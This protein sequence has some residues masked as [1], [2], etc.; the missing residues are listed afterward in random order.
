MSKGFYPLE[1]LF[2]VERDVDS[3]LFVSD[4]GDIS[5]KRF[6]ADVAGM[7]RELAG[8]SERC[9]AIY[10]DELYSFAI[11]FFSLL[12]V[13]KTIVLP[14][15]GQSG[16][17]RELA[18]CCDALLSDRTQGTMFEGLN[19]LPVSSGC[20]MVSARPFVISGDAVVKLFTSGSTGEPKMIE[21]KLCHLSREVRVLETTFGE[22]MGASM[23]YATVA[24]HHIYGLLFRLLWPLCAGRVIRTQLYDY[25]ELLLKEITA[26]PAAVLISSPAQLGRMPHIVDIASLGSCL[27]LLFSSGGP[28]GEETAWNWIE[29]LGRAPVEV[30]GSTETGGIAYRKLDEGDVWKAFDGVQISCRP[31]D[32]LLHVSSPYLANENGFTLG[33][34]IERLDKQRFLLL[35][36]VGRTVKVEEKRVSLD[37]IEE[38]LV[39]SEWVDQARVFKLRGRRRDFLGAVVVLTEVGKSYLARHGRYD[40]SGDLRDVLL[41]HFERVVLPRKWRYVEQLPLNAQGK[42]TMTVVNAMFGCA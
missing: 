3:T 34:R 18:G 28:L 35:G 38:R 16:T 20:S 39:D 19:H 31:P 32:N 7:K 2:M 37:E 40:M 27:R 23:V 4:E 25:P 24:H 29:K 15:N 22:E 17:L 36:R 9:W 41:N 5:W 42:L 13:G 21:K 11:G 30:L 33:D 1:Q 14:S 6:L 8:R 10:C 26:C 12:S